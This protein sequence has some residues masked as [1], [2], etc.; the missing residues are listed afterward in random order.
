MGDFLN[1][2]TRIYAYSDQLGY[3]CCETRVFIRRNALKEKT[4]TLTRWWHHPV[5]FSCSVIKLLFCSFG[6]RLCPGT[7]QTE[8]TWI[9][10]P[11]AE[12][13][14]W[15]VSSQQQYHGLF[16]HWQKPEIFPGGAESGSRFLSA[17]TVG[18]E[19][20]WDTL[21]GLGFLQLLH[22]FV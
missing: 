7:L 12:S 2:R 10:V 19:Q 6:K 14:A 18:S 17:G 4:L 11:H 1:S 22:I 8:F 13:S 20:Y 16:W 15:T 5:F 9:N 21:C 3:N